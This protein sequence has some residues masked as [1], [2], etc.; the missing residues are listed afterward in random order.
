MSAPTLTASSLAPYDAVILLSF[1]GP[2]QPEDV[3]PFMRNVTR[4][5]GIPEE[6]LVEVSRH[7]ALFGGR[8]PIGGEADWKIAPEDIAELVVDLVT[9][10][11]RS[12]PS[13]I[14]LRPSRP[15]PEKKA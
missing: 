6:R 8:S 3:L 13:R 9:F 5:K 12:L 4:G 14:E 10:P 7:Y 2:E 15:R 11:A 1:G